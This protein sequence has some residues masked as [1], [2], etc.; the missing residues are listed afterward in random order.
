MN[1]NDYSFH[2]ASVLNLFQEDKVINLELED[3]ET[4]SGERMSGKL[5]FLNVTTI[6]I[7]GKIYN[8]VEMYHL[9]GE[10]ICLDQDENGTTIII[11]WHSYNPRDSKTLA[12]IINA[13][14]VEWMSKN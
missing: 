7:E 9:D 11:E 2:D 1:L 12:Y 6:K 5:K 14:N 13:E 8:S 3:V 10:V 4:R